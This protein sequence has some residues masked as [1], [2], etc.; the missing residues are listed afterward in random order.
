MVWLHGGGFL[1]G[2]GNSDTFGPDWL[3]ARDMVVVTLNYRLGPFGYLNL[4]IE[5]APGN[6]GL[7]DQVSNL[8]QN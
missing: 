1:S 8:F 4:E 6:M 3:V 7:K 2:S 5:D